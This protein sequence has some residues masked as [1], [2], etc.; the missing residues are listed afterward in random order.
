MGEIEVVLHAVC[1]WK[2]FLQ[3]NYRTKR[4]NLINLIRINGYES[5]IIE[6]LGNIVCYN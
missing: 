5:C 4:V 3:L 2:C 6:Q 1:D